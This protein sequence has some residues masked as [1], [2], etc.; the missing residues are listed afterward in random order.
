MLGT[1]TIAKQW[2]EMSRT[3]ANTSHISHYIRPGNPA[4][5]QAAITCLNKRIIA[6]N[7]ELT[8]LET[9]PIVDPGEFNA[10]LA[11]IKLEVEH[12]EGAIR[13]LGYY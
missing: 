6:L 7:N 4:H 2:Q 11:A 5:H 9:I 13:Y 10:M 12:L 3:I 1:T 8:R